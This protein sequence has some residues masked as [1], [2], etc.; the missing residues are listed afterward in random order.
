MDI[1]D[2]PDPI[3]PTR[4]T[5][6]PAG[7]LNDTLLMVAWL[8][9]SNLKLTFLNSISPLSEDLLIGERFDA[10]LKLFPINADNLRYAVI[11]PL[12]LDN[13]FANCESDPSYAPILRPIRAPCVIALQ[14]L[15][16]LHKRW[17]LLEHTAVLMQ[18]SLL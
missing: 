16:K 12:T 6:W 17:L 5:F 13:V 3:L 4:A 2:F 9:P 1:V 18:Q 14:Q 8:E 11:A 7:I 10:L 15:N